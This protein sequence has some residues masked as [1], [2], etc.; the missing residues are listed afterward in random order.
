MYKL[1]KGCFCLNLSTFARYFATAA[2]IITIK[3]LIDNFID[4]HD[5]LSSDENNGNLPDPVL[6]IS[7]IWG[8]LQ[9]GCAISLRIGIYKV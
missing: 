9:L 8:F 7:I 6:L 2:I 5:I 4:L 3:L 1:K